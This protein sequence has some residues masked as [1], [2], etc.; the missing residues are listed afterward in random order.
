MAADEYGR[1]LDSL[2]QALQPGDRGAEIPIGE[3]GF[4]RDLL[5]LVLANDLDGTHCRANLGDVMDPQGPALGAFERQVRYVARA[6][7]A[8]LRH[9]YADVDIVGLGTIRNGTKRARK[10]SVAAMMAGPTSSVARTTCSET[11]P[12]GSA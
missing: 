11:L 3:I 10:D 8:R 4:N 7:D 1:P 9:E 5:G 6:S 12:S 2:K